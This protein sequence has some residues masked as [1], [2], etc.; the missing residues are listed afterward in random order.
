MYVLGG[1]L[2]GRGR[3]GGGCEGGAAL[4]IC[5]DITHVYIS[6]IMIYIYIYICIERERERER[7]RAMRI[8]SPP[9]IRNPPPLQ[10]DFV[11]GFLM[12]GVIVGWVPTPYPPPIK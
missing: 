5:I 4:Y 12:R 6:I 3:A 9:L 1:A 7:E 8:I 11:G 2:G 10:F